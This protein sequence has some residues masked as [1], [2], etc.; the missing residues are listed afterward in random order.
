MKS[1]LLPGGPRSRAVELPFQAQL[2][3]LVTLFFSL[4]LDNGQTLKLQLATP[5]EPLRHNTAL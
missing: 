1:F 2:S 4:Q 3:S 5:K